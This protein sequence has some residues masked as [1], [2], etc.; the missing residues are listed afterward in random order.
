MSATREQLN[1]VSKL[2]LNEI[3]NKYKAERDK[4]T[5][6]IETVLRRAVA[7]GHEQD[8]VLICEAVKQINAQDDNP[9][10]RRTALHW[11]AIKGHERIYSFLISKG[12]KSDIKDVEGKSAEDYLTNSALKNK[13][14]GTETGSQQIQQLDVKSTMEH[15]VN[16]ELGS[17]NPVSSLVYKSK[18]ADPFEPAFFSRSLNTIKYSKSLIA[19]SKKFDEIPLEDFLKLSGMEGWTDGMLISRSLRDGF[20]Q[21]KEYPKIARSDLEY[22]LHNPF[23]SA[24]VCESPG[25]AGLTLCLDTTAKFLPIGTILFIYAGETVEATT[26]YNDNYAM[27]LRDK[28]QQNSAV[29]QKLFKLPRVTASK[30][31]NLARFILDGPDEQELEK[32][33]N[34][35]ATALSN[36]ATRNVEV[37]SAIYKGYPVN[38]IFTVKEVYPGEQFLLPYHGGWDDAWSNERAV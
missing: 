3:L 33:T 12:A 32:V 21:D 31:G 20:W 15:K 24:V 4:T 37:L 27:T 38:I 19:L 9:E 7:Q 6:L 34:L 23:S 14:Q 13:P 10:S 5:P 26:N 29:N 30:Q 2:T 28:A 22:R 35:D 8:V 16:K 36:I 11:A 1:N 25:K 18:V 17:L